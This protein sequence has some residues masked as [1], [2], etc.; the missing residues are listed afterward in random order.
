[1]K[2]QT[3]VNAAGPL[4]I[5]AT[6]TPVAD[7]PVVLVVTG[8]AWSSS[9][10]NKIGIEVSLNGSVIGSATLFANQNSVHMT[11]P[12]LFLNAVIPSHEPQKIAVTGLGHTVT[13][14]NDH[15]TVQLL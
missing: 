3:I 1:M 14:L 10:P 9:A 8:T 11:L 2:L 12:T 7:G 15:F 6:F 5:S 13:D 4:P